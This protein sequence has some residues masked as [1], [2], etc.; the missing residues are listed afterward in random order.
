MRDR[1]WQYAE[2]RPGLYNAISPL[3]RVLA[4]NCGACPQ[5]GFALLKSG[6]VYANTIAVLAYAEFQSFAIVQ[7]RIHELWARFFSSS[8]KDDLRYAP[9]DCFRTFPFP[10]NFETD[11]T[12][13]AAGE[14]YHAFRAELMIARNEG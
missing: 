10:V 8:M 5:F 4:I 14:A 11:V 6:S 9:S 7:C 2:K 3:S 13:E 1:W 12:L